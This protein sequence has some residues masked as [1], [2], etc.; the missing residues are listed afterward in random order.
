MK[1]LITIGF[2]ALFTGCLLNQPPTPRTVDIG[3][4]AEKKVNQVVNNIK[5]G[6]SSNI[7]L[8]GSL[9]LGLLRGRLCHHCA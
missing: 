1:L 8:T 3:S 9:D 2:C 6:V 4:L 7:T 5:S